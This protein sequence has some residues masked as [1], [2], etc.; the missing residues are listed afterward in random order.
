M[1]QDPP[2][3]AGRALPGAPDVHGTETAG[4]ERGPQC[5]YEN[6]LSP[7]SSTG[8]RARPLPSGR[9]HPSNLLVSI[10]TSVLHWG[11]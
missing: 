7:W 10:T 8:L 6:I 1:S 2:H 11:S 5:L 3:H 9:P 4:Q